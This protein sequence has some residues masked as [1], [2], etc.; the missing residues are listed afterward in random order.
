MRPRAA[1]S[2]ASTPRAQARRTPHRSRIAASL[3]LRRGGVGRALV[4]DPA[5]LQVI[6]LLAALEGELDVGVL[7]DAT[8]PIGREHVLAVIFEGQLLD[9]MR[10]NDL[11]LGVLDEAGI[12]RMLDQCLHLGGLAARSSAHANARCHLNSPSSLFGA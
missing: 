5:Y 6:A 2:Q 8:A 4:V 9:E 7:R 3:D 12:H 11:A 10:R 1:C